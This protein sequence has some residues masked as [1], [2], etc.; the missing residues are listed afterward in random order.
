LELI[1]ITDRR[2]LA[3]M[4][5]LGAA[6]F[7]G[8]WNFTFLSPVL[9]SVAEDTDVSTSVAGQLVTVSALVTVVSVI[10]FGPLSDRYGRRPTLM[11]GLA[12]M[13]L[14][15]FGSS[16]TSDYSI[17]MSLRVLS[18]MADA[19][20]LPSAAAAVSDYYRDK[21]REVALNVLLIPMGAAAVVGL[22]V[23]AI[24][25]N[26]IDWHAAFLVF[27]GL[28][29]AILAG[30]IWALP[31][32]A[33]TVPRNLTLGDHY[34]E[35][36]GEVLGTRTALVVLGAAVLGATVWN[37]T[38]TYAGA[39]FEDEL[40]VGGTGVSAMFAALGIAYVIGGGIGVLVARRVAPRP[41][42]LWSAV[43]ASFL[44]LPLVGSSALPVVTV[45][46]AVAFAASR[47]PGIAA[48]NNMLLDLAPGAQGTAIGTYGVVA[49]SGALLGAAFGGAAIALEGYY[50]MAT[51]FTTLAVGSALLLLG[52]ADEPVE[53]TVSA[54]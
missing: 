38:V 18:G 52:P 27:A 3:I 43:A 9:P 42:A 26:A 51:L 48:L 11:A 33:P 28:N 7:L 25:D 47:A 32:V 17:L 34:R 54:S 14:A 15:A 22:P 40:G 20:V 19:L 16:L 2:S 30:V 39:F 49:A 1:V 8:T 45:I 10:I 37:G 4:G 23:V 35:S 24:I 36:Y 41:I 12:V 50:A 46:V 53:R 6:A 21:D 29:A 31:A 44:L 13:G 5:L